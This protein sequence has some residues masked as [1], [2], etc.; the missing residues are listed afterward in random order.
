MKTKDQLKDDSKGRH[1]PPQMAARRD[2]QKGTLWDLRRVPM[3][4]LSMA[5]PM[6]GQTGFA[7][8]VSMGIAKAS[9]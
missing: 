5:M 1:W 2:L 9:Q 8:A 4:D 3:S 6:A 7:K